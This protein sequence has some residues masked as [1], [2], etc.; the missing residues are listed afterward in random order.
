MMT[1]SPLWKIFI[2]ARVAQS[3]VGN[4]L[5][6][7]RGGRPGQRRHLKAI[8]QRPFFEDHSGYEGLLES[9]RNRDSQAGPERGDKGK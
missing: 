7:F 1:A 6:A 4:L 9:R 3:V 2:S 5:L 8:R